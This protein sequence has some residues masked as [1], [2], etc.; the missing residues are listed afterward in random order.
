MEKHNSQN[1][2]DILKEKKAKTIT[3][4]KTYCQSYTSIQVNMAL[5]KEKYISQWKI[6]ESK[7]SSLFKWSFFFLK[8]QGNKLEKKKKKQSFK[9]WEIHV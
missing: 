4:F 2:Q 9:Q 5:A 3:D 6:I 1:R 8:F 7:N